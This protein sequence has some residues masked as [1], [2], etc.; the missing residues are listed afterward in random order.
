MPESTSTR[1]P[2]LWS[3]QPSQLWSVVIP[4]YYH[5]GTDRL[6][7][8]GATHGEGEQTQCVFGQ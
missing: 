5:G 3:A 8:G 7:F 6:V 1:G 4:W 2:F